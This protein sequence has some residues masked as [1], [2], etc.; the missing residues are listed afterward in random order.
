MCAYIV[1]TPYV[2]TYGLATTYTH[3]RK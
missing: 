2:G 1:A 3:T